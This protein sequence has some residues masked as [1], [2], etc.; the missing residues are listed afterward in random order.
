MNNSIL[1]SLLAAV[2]L[3]VSTLSAERVPGHYIVELSTESVTDAVARS[4]RRGAMRT[5]EAEGQRTRVRTEQQRLRGSLELRKAR[6]LDSVSN[7]ANAMFVEVA[8]ADAA[9]L[10]KLPGVRRVVPVR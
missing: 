1:Y 3:F 8:D 2:L 4:G 6:V 9:D 10:A 7:V 5:A